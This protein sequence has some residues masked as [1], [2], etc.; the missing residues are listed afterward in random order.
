MILPRVQAVVPLT[1]SEAEF[2]AN[3]LTYPDL[4]Y[5][6]I[7]FVLEQANDFCPL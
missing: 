5:L 6:E 2:K 7:G 4:S 1:S 3:K